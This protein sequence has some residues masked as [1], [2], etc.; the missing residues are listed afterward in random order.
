MSDPHRIVAHW[1]GQL[2]RDRGARAAIRRAQTWD[3]VLTVPAF[4]DLYRRIHTAGIRMRPEVLGRIGLAVAEI[5]PRETSAEGQA[6]AYEL[7]PGR[8]FGRPR[9][10]ESRAPVSFGR[11]RRLVET[12]EPD[13]FV[14]LLRAALTQAEGEGHPAHVSRLVHAWHFPAGRLSARRRLLLDYAETAPESEFRQQGDMS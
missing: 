1:H 14:R 11:L 7:R 2:L 4:L 3:G 12:E 10:G 13:L 9:R 5:E 8:V 6:D